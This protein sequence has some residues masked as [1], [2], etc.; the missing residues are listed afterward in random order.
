M[1]A[2]FLDSKVLLFLFD[3]RS[4]RKFGVA[5][6]LVYKALR[7]GNMEISTEDLQHEQIIG[8]LKIINPFLMDS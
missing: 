7:A 1:S 3:E 6:K 2:S 4:H 8:K 5:E